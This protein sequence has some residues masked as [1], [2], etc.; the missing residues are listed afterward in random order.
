VWIGLGATL[1][2]SILTIGRVHGHA[3]AF[4]D[5]AIG[6]EKAINEYRADPTIVDAQLAKAVSDG[7]D[8]HRRAGRNR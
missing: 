1:C 5:M 6:L 3:D 2:A 4:D 8:I 7:L